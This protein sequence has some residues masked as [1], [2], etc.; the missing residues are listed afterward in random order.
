M[1]FFTMQWWYDVQTG[2]AEDVAALYFAHFDELRRRLA[3]S[4]IATFEALNRAGLHDSQLRHLDLD[5]ANRT[6]RVDF[7]TYWPGGTIHLTY[8]GVRR[9]T[10]SSDP[11][12]GFASPAGYGD[13]GYDEIDRTPDGLFVH[14]LLFSSGIEWE[15]EFEEFAHERRG[16]PEPGG[17]PTVVG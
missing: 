1:K 13:A 10:T 17:E 9:F 12:L 3:P 5:L 15:I 8:R 6:L 4:Q 11:K 7:D 14:R 16:E 2:T